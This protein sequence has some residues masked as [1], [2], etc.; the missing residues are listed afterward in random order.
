MDMAEL[1]FRLV[2]ICIYIY[3]YIYS[4]FAAILPIGSIQFNQLA[5]IFGKTTRINAWHV[6]MI[7]ENKPTKHIPGTNVRFPWFTYDFAVGFQQTRIRA[8]Y[9]YVHL[10]HV[11]LALN[12]P[13]G[14]LDIE[15]WVILYRKYT[16]HKVILKHCTLTKTA[17][18]DW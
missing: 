17:I 7:Y 11:V 18:S 1:T 12:R 6:G 5:G 10:R 13:Y 3:I 16:E 14:K 4:W 9:Y 15:Y 2:Y 8:M